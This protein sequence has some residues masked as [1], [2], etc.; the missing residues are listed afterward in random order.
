MK[1]I[2]WID[3]ETTGLDVRKDAILEIGVLRSRFDRPFDAE[4]I[5]HAELQWDEDR[6]GLHPAVRA[7]HERSGLFDRCR[8]SP[9]TIY[10]VTHDLC[11][12]VPLES[13]PDDRAVL[14]GSTVHFDKGFLERDCSP[15]VQ[16]LSH[17]LYDV[18]AIKLFCQSLGMPKL[19]KAEA[20]TAIDDI[21]E[22][23]RHAR[24]C[25]YW[26]VDMHHTIPIGVLP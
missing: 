2:I 19:P 16:H 4:Q 5:Y 3:I 8:Q 6:T 12:L 24:E 7:M 11:K 14:G 22:S 25:A 17:R 20:H 18:S 21:R 13:E 26:L 1:H 23:V 10:S 15:F 9:H